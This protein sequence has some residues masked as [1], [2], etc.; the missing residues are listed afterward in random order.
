MP[1]IIPMTA[2]LLRDYASSGA[3]VA[4][5]LRAR[6]KLRVRARASVPKGKLARRESKARAHCR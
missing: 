6:L 2:L 3:G 5:M 1:K 4:S